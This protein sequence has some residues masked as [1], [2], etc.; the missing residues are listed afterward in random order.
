M[1][2]ENQQDSAALHKGPD[3]TPGRI[4]KVFFYLLG[5]T[6]IEFIIALVF[7]HGGIIAKG[8]FVISV[9]I[10]LTLIKAYYIIAYFMHLKFETTGF[11]TL[12]SIGML[13]LI[14]F[15]ILMFIEGGYLMEHLFKT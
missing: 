10:V 12:I 1:I 6:A 5:L 13:L 9:Y 7:V 8:P 14:Y 11:I 15:I 2:T 4:W 3:M